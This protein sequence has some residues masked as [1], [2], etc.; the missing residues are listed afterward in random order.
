M[1]TKEQRQYWANRR[2][3]ER[4]MIE[5]DRR[6][7]QHRVDMYLPTI[8]RPKPKPSRKHQTGIIAHSLQEFT[9]LKK[10]HPNAEVH[11]SST[12]S[13]TQLFDTAEIIDV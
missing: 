6:E 11:Y 9:E 1:Q 3:A 8:E 13:Q 12:A 5:H 2:K 4:P 7:L 10:Q